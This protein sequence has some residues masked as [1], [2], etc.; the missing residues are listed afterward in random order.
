MIGRTLGHYEIVD[1]ELHR[2]VGLADEVS[3]PSPDLS[4]ALAHES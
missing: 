1:G 2:L 3:P 4:A